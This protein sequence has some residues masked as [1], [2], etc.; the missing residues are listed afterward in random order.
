MILQEVLVLLWKLPGRGEVID[1]DWVR[2]KAQ[3]AKRSPISRSVVTYLIPTCG[4]N[5]R[6]HLIRHTFDIFLCFCDTI[7]PRLFQSIGNNDGCSG[8]AYAID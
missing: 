7:P 2:E 8:V 3:E 4:W 5:H 1:L 6:R